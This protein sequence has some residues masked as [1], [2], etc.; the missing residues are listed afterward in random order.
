[1]TSISRTNT[2]INRES[3]HEYAVKSYKRD[4]AHLKNTFYFAG[5]CLFLPESAARG[6]GP[7]AGTIMGLA[8]APFSTT[9]GLVT[10]ALPV[11]A[12]AAKTVLDGIC[13]RLSNK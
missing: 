9:A 12:L 7:V 13:M 8:V 6:M 10:L 1:M 5:D 11:P 3:F 4:K 2:T